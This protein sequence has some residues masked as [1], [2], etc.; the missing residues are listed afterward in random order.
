VWNTAY[1]GAY[2]GSTLGGYNA[3]VE[4]RLPATVADAAVKHV[5]YRIVTDLQISER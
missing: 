2:L 1:S 5:T 4:G 3:T